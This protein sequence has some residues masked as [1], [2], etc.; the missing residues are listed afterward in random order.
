MRG[1]MGEI[2]PRRVVLK[3]GTAAVV[4]SA[5][6]SDAAEVFRHG[7]G[8]IEEDAFGVTL[9][10][11]W[12]MTE[13][14]ER[15]WI[16]KHTADEGAV[17]IVAEVDGRIVGM[18]NYK[19]IGRKRMRHHGHFGIGVDTDWRERGVGRELVR[20]LLD[21]ARAHPFV[22]CVRLGVF[23]NN[24]RAIHLYRS[25]GFVETHRNVREFKM[26][27]GAEGYVDDIQMSCWV[28]EPGWDAG[29]KGGAA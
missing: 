20:A 4:R 14:K 11:E 17:V 21:W 29:G 22:E 19:S 7:R 15:E 24:P 8:L 13:E 9:I 1:R 23:A 18:A 10:E 26:R 28:K 12:D 2:K 5:R 27:A 25:M 16:E 6:T 3:D